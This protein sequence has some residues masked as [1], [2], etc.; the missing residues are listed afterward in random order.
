MSIG[1]VALRW[2]ARSWENV[3]LMCRLFGH[4]WTEGWWG[5]EPYL[6]PRHRPGYVDGIGRSHVKLECRCDRCGEKSHV[7]NVHDWEKPDD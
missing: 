6:T 2:P 3:P 7:A 1:H 4:I 5:S